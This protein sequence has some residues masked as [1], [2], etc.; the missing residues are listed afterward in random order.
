MAA[1]VSLNID[2]FRA[3]ARTLS[4]TIKATTAELKAQ[5]I[6]FKGSEKSVNGMKTVYGTLERQSKQLQARLKAEQQTLKERS[7]AVAKGGD[8]MEKLT[9]REANAAAA[10]NKTAAQIANNKNRME[11][12]NKEI[13]LQSS[14]WTKLS[15]KAMAFSKVTGKIG[16]ALS[17]FGSKATM[18]VTAPLAVGFTAAAKSAIDFNSQISS[19]GPLLTNGGTVTAKYRAQLDKMAESS[20]KWAV[21]YGTS[22]KSINDGMSEMVKRGYSAEQTMGAMPSIL[23]ATKASGDDFNDVMH[24][25]TSVLE[26]FGLKSNSTAGMLK[27]TQ[28]VT[29]SLTLIANKTAAGFQDMGEAMTYVGP[30]ANSAGISLEQTAAAIGL[31]S[32]QGIEGSV[33]GTALRGAL[34]R[35][36]KPSKQNAQGF[37]ELGINVADFKKGTLT[38]PDMLDKIKKNTTGWTKEQKSAAIA[39]AFG[40]NAQAGMNV[41]I[42][43]GGDALRKMTSDAKNASG[44]TAKIA[45]SMNNTQAAKVAKFKES[46]NVLGIT[47]GQKLLPTLTPLIDKATQVIKSFSEMDSHTQ[48]SIIKWGLFAAAVGP[49][50]RTL[51]SVF[52]VMH[53]TGSAIG[54]V[55]GGLGRATTAAKLGAGG[56]SIIKS[57]FSKTAFEALKVAPA[58]GVAADGLGVAGAAGTGLLASLAP[59]APAILGVAAVAGTGYAAWKLWG[60]GAVESANRTKE[61]GSDIGASADKSAG[62]IK[63]ASGEI[64]GALDNTNQSAKTNAKQI[65]EG[66]NSM[67]KAAQKAATESDK[68]AKKLAKSLGGS[69]GDALLKAAAKEKAADDKRIAQMKSNTKK[70]E[71]I[72]RSANKTGEA[73]TADQIQILDNLRKDDAQKA[74]K[75]LKLS[76]SEQKNV[77]KAIL[78]EKTK[79]TA[80]QAAEQRQDSLIAWQQEAIDYNKAQTKIKNDAK[81]TK[82]EKNA[83]LEG[84]EKDHQSKLNTIYQGAIQAMKSQGMS[85]HE[86]QQQLQNDYGLTETAAE[87]SM[88]A[89]TKAMSKGVQSN[90]QFAAAVSDGMSASAK[91]AGNAWNSLVLNPKTGK[92]V[93]NLSQVLKD[94]ANTKVGWNKLVFELKYAKISSN[95]KQAIV[96]ALTASDQWKSMPTWEKNAV[97]RVQG[98]NE[99]ADIME[100]YVDW[101]SLSLKEQRAIVHGDYSG[102]VN[103]LVEAG[104]WQK[105]TL[106]QQQ[107]IVKNKATAPIIS[108]L[109][110]SGKWNGLTME[111]KSAVVNAKGTPQL[112][113]A[114]IKYKLWNQ[115]PDKEKK[116]LINNAD[117]RKKLAA[118]NLDLGKYNSVKVAE[119]MFKANEKS[120]KTSSKSAEDQIA[121]INKMKTKTKVFKGDAK[122]VKNKSK[123][124]QDAV[125]KN[126]SKKVDTKFFKG[127]S[128]SIVA[129]GK[130][131]MGTLKSF[132]GTPVLTKDYKGVDHASANA[133]RATKAS[134]EFS[135]QKNHTVWYKAIFQTIKSVITG[136]HKKTGSND[137][138]DGLAVVNDATGGTFREAITLPSGET[139]IPQGRNVVMAL[140]RHARIE[141]ATATARKYG[142][143]K[144]ANGTSD[145][146]GATTTLQNLHSETVQAVTVQSSSTTDDGVAKAL[147]TLNVLVAELLDYTPSIEGVVQLD[148]SRE[149]GHW[150]AKSVTNEQ[151]R[152][153]RLYNRSR[154]VNI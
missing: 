121:F 30:V 63:K 3:S 66:F 92:V 28:R 125:S 94:T 67:T 135:K 99:L 114:V 58:A 75:T 111:E 5:D 118:S 139:F 78:G 84:L 100:E 108:A 109:A 83:T 112:A 72:T 21:Q 11:A 76:G 102:L 126:N 145:F 150:V 59:I 98:R 120:V 42:S 53:G 24:V 87:N 148:N 105:L 51:G 130:T 77:L 69:A 141:T 144:F 22:T 113:D 68:A 106:K 41:L 117:A 13:L 33:A 10:L 2:P 152:A 103:G 25:S 81:L 19:I 82:A 131:S 44:T 110:E 45:E 136:K 115:L 26:Q 47:I 151:A 17:S 57:A 50:A 88:D 8:D 89:Y 54:A 16:G 34:T 137:F 93:T 40:T 9:T 73:L 134:K 124:S 27:N 154:G 60:E 91:K 96:D 127:D 37:K 52:N 116:L 132:N 104:K 38:L 79:M 35:L 107:A 101:N 32:N 46:I 20:K 80:Q 14:S 138:N 61:W 39:T 140:P 18:A 1:T 31:M 15:E 48:Q 74:I 23:D 12:L 122:D 70:A 6:A 119:K 147:K 128:K 49:V 62:A 4:S 64:S 65:A 123:E 133:N 36:M 56:F 142:I 85:N 95:A 129:S 86:V 143:P 55:T 71:S 43:E 146:T 29:D 90:K 153:N 97:I 7:E 149:V